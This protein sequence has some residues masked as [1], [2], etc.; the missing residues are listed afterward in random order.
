M[1]RILSFLTVFVLA[2]AVMAQSDYISFRADDKSDRIGDLNGAGGVLVLSKRGDLVITVTNTSQYRT[3]PAGR[4]ASGLYEYEVVVSDVKEA[5][6]EINR[7]G[8]V[9]RTSFVS[10]IKPNFYRAYIIEEVQ[11]PIRMENQSQANDAVLDAKLAEVEFTTTIADLKV[12]CP[13]A[14]GAEIKTTRKSTDK[15]IIVTSVMIPIKILEDARQ[16]QQSTTAAAAQLRKQLV[17]D[18]DGSAKASDKDWERLDILEDAAEQADRHLA[19]LSSIYISG[20]GTN[21]LQVDISELKPR[22]KMCYSVLLLT[23]EVVQDKFTALVKEAGRYYGLRQYDNAKR[24][25]TNALA[26][27]GAPA[28]LKATVKSS[29]GQCDSC[30]AY[31]RYALGAIKRI[32]E[33]KSTNSQE[34]LVKYASAGIEYLQVLNKFNPCDFY[35]GRIESLE[36]LIAGLPLEIRFTMVRWV[37]NAAGFFEAGKIPNVEVWAYTGATPP[38]PKNYNTLKRFRDMVGKSN[39]Y[40]QIGASNA[41]GQA[42]VQLDRQS[43]PTGLFF[44]PTDS[45]DKI[46]IEY[47]DFQE[48]MHQTSGTY[49]KRRF[50][51]KMFAAY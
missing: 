31:E 37:N 35:D 2:Q 27:P 43:L 4:N 42:D 48:L 33:L 41:E 11:R 49:N 18:P 34:E 24:I 9:Y 47:K 16:Q 15:S 26:E 13:S 50:R 1:R 21:R 10:K 22:S 46:K 14:L 36:K 28:D 3:T 39:D 29:I 6:L 23:K 25:F 8:D 30:M 5:K 44:C 40:C 32:K 38:M 12:E 20:E 45:G 7:R 17:D 51:L 19:E